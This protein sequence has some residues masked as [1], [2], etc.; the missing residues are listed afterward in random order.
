MSCYIWN[1][2]IVTNCPDTIEFVLTDQECNS[3]AQGTNKFIENLLRDI[4]IEANVAS[5]LIKPCR[6]NYYTDFLGEDDWRDVWQLVWKTRAVTMEEITGLPKLSEPYIES[7]ADDESW[8]FADRLH[9]DATVGCLVISDFDNEEDRQKTQAAIANDELI[10]NMQKQYSVSTLTF[11]Y[12]ELLGKYKQLQIYLGDF[13]G[14][15]FAQGAD[16]AEHVL[17]LCKQAGGTVHFQSRD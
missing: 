1:P 4:G 16:Y 3:I 2:Y 17:E 9:D 8:S 6:S 11:S 5:W 14:E 13:P 7:E 12:S 10:K 15:F